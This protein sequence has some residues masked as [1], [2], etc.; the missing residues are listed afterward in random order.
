MAAQPAGRSEAVPSAG[1]D[2]A[3]PTW[4]ALRRLRRLSLSGP[5]VGAAGV[6][7]LAPLSASLTSI[8]LGGASMDDAALKALTALKGL[9]SCSIVVSLAWLAPLLSFRSPS[10]MH[11][12]IVV[13]LPQAMFLDAWHRDYCTVGCSIV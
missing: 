13:S 12:G 9:Q 7:A 4:G 1:H 6:Q 8:R 5:C 2:E 3:A 11:P 10:P